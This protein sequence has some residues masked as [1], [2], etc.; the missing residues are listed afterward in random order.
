MNKE[1]IYIYSGCMHCVQLWA[2]RFDHQKA[3][4]ATRRTNIHIRST[5]LHWGINASRRWTP[6]LEIYLYS[7]PVWGSS[8]MIHLFKSK[9]AHERLDRQS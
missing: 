7:F 3:A 9:K 6:K 1:C 8:V 5:G 2:A 4:R